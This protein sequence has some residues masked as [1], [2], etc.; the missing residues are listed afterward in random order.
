MWERRNCPS[1]PPPS[2]TRRTDLRGKTRLRSLGITEGLGM[3]D[4]KGHSW[5]AAWTLNQPKIGSAALGQQQIS[6]VLTPAGPVSW[7]CMAKIE[8]IIGRRRAV[9][10]VQA[11]SCVT[12]AMSISCPHL[13]VSCSLAA[14]SKT[15][16]HPTR[17]G[18]HPDIWP[19]QLN[20]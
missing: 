12:G 20:D 15:R 1:P 7:T 18:L 5:T 3:V 2:L 6:G 13:S 8:P 11:R 16:D 14:L 10:E 17:S 19:L 9:Q 4:K